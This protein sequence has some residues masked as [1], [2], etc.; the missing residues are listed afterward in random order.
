MKDES[1]G[2]RGVMEYQALRFR[3]AIQSDAAVLAEFGRRTFEETFGAANTPDDMAAYLRSNYG[4][5]QQAAELGDPDIITIVAEAKGVLAAYAQVRRGPAPEVV[6]TGPPVELWRFYVDHPWQGL[7]LAQ[8][9][10]EHVHTAAA[11]L[12]GRAI[13]L[14][15]WDQNARA[16]AFYK[17][18]GFRIAGTKDFWLGSDKQS[19]Y[20]M[21]TVMRKANPAPE[22][23]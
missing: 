17:K 6:R 23:L 2:I 5:S 10:L 14:S 18:S 12:G 19:D 15:V 4:T 13:W 8:Q 21:L 11:E 1:A 9:L 16:I 22:F 7:G 3:R 20:V